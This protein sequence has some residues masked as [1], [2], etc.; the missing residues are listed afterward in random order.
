MSVQRSRLWLRN[1]NEQIDPR[2]PQT[3]VVPLKL[4]DRDHNLLEV[5][6]VHRQN[7]QDSGPFGLLYYK[8]YWDGGF[9][10]MDEEA[11]HPETFYTILILSRNSLRSKDLV[12]G[13]AILPA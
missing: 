1:L 6:L 2:P 10:V 11:L 8:A 9:W 5:Q 3:T 12:V 13:P 4:H 7:H